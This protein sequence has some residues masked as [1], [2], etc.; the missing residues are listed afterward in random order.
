MNF[1]IKFDEALTLGSI[2]PTESVTSRVQAPPTGQ[3]SGGAPLILSKG[4]TSFIMERIPTHLSFEKPGYRQ[5]GKFTA[6]I[7]FRDLPIDPRT[8]RAAAVEIHLGTVSNEQFAEG[9]KQGRLNADFVGRSSVLQTRSAD[10]GINGETL[11]MLAIVDDWWIEN[12]DKGSRVELSGRDLRGVLLDTPV[13]PGGKSS[14]QFLESLDLGRDVGEV[15]RQILSYNPFFSDFRVVINPEDWPNGHVPNPGGADVMPRHSKGAR[16]KKKA[17]RQ[18]PGMDTKQLNFWDII[19]QVCYLVGAIPYFVGSEIVIRPASSVF[20]KLRGPVDP[21]KN[22]TPFA[23]GQTRTL[24]AVAHTPIAPDLRVRRLVYGRDT[25]SL[26]LG[27]KYGGWRRPKVVRCISLDLSSGGLGLDKVV[28]GLWPPDADERAKRTRVAPSGQ[29]VM[30]EA[31]T[32]RAPAGITD[33]ARCQ[34][35]ARA[36]YEEIG[37]GEMGGEVVTKNLASF[38]GDN[39]DPDLLRLEPGDGVEILTDTRA[40]NAGA[41]LVS[42]YVDWSRNSFEDQ[43]AEITNRIG[44]EDLA[45]VVVATARGQ[46]A[47][48]QRFFR[49]QNVKFNCDAQSGVKISFDFQNYVVARAQVESSRS[50]QGTAVSAAVAGAPPVSPTTRGRSLRS[51]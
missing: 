41:P 21:K 4:Q 38:G 26:K 48:L 17:G 14:Q 32:I 23:G 39:S 15:V 47:E 34:E 28:V 35:I 5:A 45:R 3:G 18:P 12:D 50:Q 11:R 9:M 36:V 31:V 20:D 44:D 10:G 37:R 13:N 22:P 40:I 46:V 43:V 1:K 19:V 16:G 6:T 29:V 42:T 25:T 27:R 51:L 30:E 49:V 8:V 7:P 24:D 33:P 2:P